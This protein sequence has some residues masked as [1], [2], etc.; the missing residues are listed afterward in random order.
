MLFHNGGLRFSRIA[1]M[2]SG[3]SFADHFSYSL[4]SAGRVLLQRCCHAAKRDPAAARTAGVLRLDQ[5]LS[6]RGQVLKVLNALGILSA[7]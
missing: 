4:T 7:P 1:F 2:V 3:F 6:A 5:T